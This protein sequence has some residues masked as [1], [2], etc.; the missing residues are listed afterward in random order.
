MIIGG[1]LLTIGILVYFIYNP[2]LPPKGSLSYY[3]NKWREI[4]NF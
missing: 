4:S 2:R 1:I 3:K